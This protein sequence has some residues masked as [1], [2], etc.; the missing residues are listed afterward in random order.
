MLCQ[1]TLRS[2]AVCIALGEN[3]TLTKTMPEKIKRYTDLIGARQGSDWCVAFVYWCYN[4]ASGELGVG[5]PMIKTGSTGKLYKFADQKNLFVESPASGDLYISKKKSHTGMIAFSNP[6]FSNSKTK[7][8]EGNTW[9][10]D[11][12]W[13]VHERKKN[14]AEA[15]FIRL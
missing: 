8:I 4:K 15:Y 2:R 3:K 6:D 5:N 7:T 1:N 9:T 11:R 10:G 13:G 14:L 12:V